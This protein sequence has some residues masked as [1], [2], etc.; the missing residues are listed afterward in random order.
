MRFHGSS[1]SCSTFSVMKKK[2]KKQTASTF[3]MKNLCTRLKE[4]Q[5]KTGSLSRSWSKRKVYIVLS[6]LCSKFNFICSLK[7][8][9]PFFFILTYWNFFISL[10]TLKLPL[11]S[12][13]SVVFSLF[14]TQASDR[15]LSLHVS[16]RFRLT[17]CWQNLQ[18][19]L[20]HHLTHRSSRKTP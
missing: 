16:T 11:E 5:F 10:F 12:V 2:N 9:F 19:S 7:F 1:V 6:N 14:F 15:K 13:C 3:C 4:N 8:P 20:P 17:L 18:Y